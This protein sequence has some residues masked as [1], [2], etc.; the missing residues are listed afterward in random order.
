MQ[1]L[2]W[3]GPAGVW[4]LEPLGP[5]SRRS[6]LALGE[7]QLGLSPESGVS[8]RLTLKGLSLCPCLPGAFLSRQQLFWTM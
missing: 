4:G 6:W 7:K 3:R 1:T 8:Y 5:P 2:P